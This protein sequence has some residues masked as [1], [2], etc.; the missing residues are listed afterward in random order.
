[1]TNNIFAYSL[2]WQLQLSRPESHRSFTFSN[3]IVYWSPGALF[4]GLFDR[5]NVLME[6]NLY[7]NASGRA[8]SFTPVSL[9]WQGK[10]VE[11]MTAAL[12]NAPKTDLARWQAKGRDAGSV[13][14][15]PMFEDAAR[16]DFRL[17]SASPAKRIGFVPFDY[18]R[19]GVY[20]DAAW[21][22]EA[23]GRR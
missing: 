14:A 10:D 19:A 17:K 23:A 4:G 9:E 12:A 6:K 2:Q 15:D 20:G 7:W 3:N 21:I 11:A 16:Y 5:A 18:A 1:M 13:V 22:K 8:I